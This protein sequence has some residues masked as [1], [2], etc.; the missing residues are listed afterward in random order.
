[1]KRIQELVQA[2]PP[3][4]LRRALRREGKEGT[5]SLTYQLYRRLRERKLDEDAIAVKLYGAEANRSHGSYRALKTRLS[6]LLVEAILE[7]DVARPSYQTYEDAYEHG[8]RQLEV[9]RILMSKRLYASAREVASQT[10]RRVQDF[11]ILPLNT[12]LTD[13]LS[14]LHL[15]VAYNEKLF[16]KY[17]E[18]YVRYSRASFDL[19]NITDHY[20]QVRN[21]IYANRL[22]PAEIGRIA[23]EFVEQDRPLM[24]RNDGV[25]AIQTMF[26]QTEITGLTLR[27]EYKAAIE[28]AN[29]GIVAIERCKGHSVRSLTMLALSRIACTI[30]LRDF[31]A[32]V[33]QIE[34]ARKRTPQGSINDLKI[35][36]LA[37]KLGLLTGEYVYAYEALAEVQ[38]R[39]LKRLLTV[40][41][42]EFW[43]IIEAYIHLLI[44]AGALKVD[45]QSRPLQRFRLNKFLNNVPGNVRNKRG[46]NIQVLVL[47]TVLLILQHKLDEAMD[48]VDALSVYCNRYLRDDENLRNNG[49]FKLLLI[50]INANFD[51]TVAER[52]AQKTLAA[53]R[54]A[55]E[56]GQLND[57][58]LVPYEVVWRILL[59][60]LQPSSRR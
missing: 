34:A 35:S 18:L 45:D 48:R 12:G 13:V 36:E 51:T 17:H 16:S 43:S 6:H 49:I 50:L 28:S 60:Y 39:G 33:Q 3:G 32:G 20:R 30:K 29:R 5:A 56:R 59:D 58:E 8:Y 1:M 4:T 7:E 23:A 57:L 26:T 27:G 22:A 52:K 53:M 11:E 54:G 9:A 40:A 24:E 38:S 42:Q 14:S 44:L 2:C 15:G 46:A 41:H 19:T 21:Y 31:E 10:F 37:I 55:A 47:Q 25:P